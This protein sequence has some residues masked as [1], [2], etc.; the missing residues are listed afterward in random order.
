MTR[1]LLKDNIKIGKEE[2]MRKSDRKARE[3]ETRIIG[4][5]S[6]EP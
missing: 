5:A 2:K 3:K 6:R 1:V 4:G